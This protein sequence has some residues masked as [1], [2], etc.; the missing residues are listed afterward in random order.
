M[1]NLI[2]GLISTLDV[3]IFKWKFLYKGFLLVFWMP[4][5]MILF[6][7]PKRGKKAFRLLRKIFKLINK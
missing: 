4:I 1:D 6:F 5:F 7:F 2:G 3:E